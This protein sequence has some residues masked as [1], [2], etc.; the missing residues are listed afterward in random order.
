MM[1]ILG[2]VFV[3]VFFF[4]YFLNDDLWL[5][6]PVQ[7]YFLW[8]FATYTGQRRNYLHMKKP[9]IGQNHLKIFENSFSV[10]LSFHTSQ[11]WVT[12]HWPFLSSLVVMTTVFQGVSC[13]HM[14]LINTTLSQIQVKNPKLLSGKKQLNNTRVSAIFEEYSVSVHGI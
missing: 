8:F 1:I 2:I 13:C 11:S 3:W 12:L 6:F 5:H 4:P 9:W 14:Q 7:C 10:F